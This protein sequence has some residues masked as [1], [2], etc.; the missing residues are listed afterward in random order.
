MK[1]AT[2][3]AL[4]GTTALVP[5]AG[6]AQANNPAQPNANQQAGQAQQRQTT[7]QNQGLP[8]SQLRNQP[9]HSQTG[10]ELG[11]VHL[12]VQGRTTRS[13]RSS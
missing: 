11:R 7:Q 12:L 8:A 3:A 13:T 1:I 10:R 9:V 2:F 4:L 6:L 5:T